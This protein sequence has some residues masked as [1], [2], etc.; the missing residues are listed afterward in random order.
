MP[1]LTHVTTKT[2]TSEILDIID[3]EGAVIIDAILSPDETEQFADE[4]APLLKAAAQGQDSFSGFST[5]RVGALIARSEI[6]RRMATNTQLLEIADGMLGKFSE[7]VQL[8]FSPK[9]LLCHPRQHVGFGTYY[10]SKNRN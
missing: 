5:T 8:S 10:K 1:Q 4:L 2:P 6:C 3:R 9:L 7:T